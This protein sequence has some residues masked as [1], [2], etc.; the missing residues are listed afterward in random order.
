MSKAQK[1]LVLFVGIV[2]VIYIIASKAPDTGTQTATDRQG[3]TAKPKDRPQDAKPKDRPQEEAWSPQS[4]MPTLLTQEDWCLVCCRLSLLRST[5]RQGGRPN[6]VV[7][8]VLRTRVASHHP[9]DKL[10][11]LGDIIFAFGDVSSGLD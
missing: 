5:L 3:E 1:M 8:A 10:A 7:S 9:F 4:E 6:P 2:F 11:L